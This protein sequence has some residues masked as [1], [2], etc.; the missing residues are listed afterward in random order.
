MEFVSVFRWAQSIEAFPISGH[1]YQHRTGYINQAHHKLSARVKR[2]IKLIK[3]LHTYEP[4]VSVV[5]ALCYKPEDRG[6]R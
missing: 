2:N 1:L 3:T 5:E 4:L 6:F